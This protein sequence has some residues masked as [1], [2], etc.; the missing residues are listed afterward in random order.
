MR[1]TK[2]SSRSLSML[3]KTLTI[4]ICMP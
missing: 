4:S 3:S 1:E 2:I